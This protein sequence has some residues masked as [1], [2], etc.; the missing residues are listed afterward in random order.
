MKEEGACF[1]LRPGILAAR[2]LAQ[3]EGSARV[4][5][6]ISAIADAIGR[7]EQIMAEIDKRWPTRAASNDGQPVHS[8]FAQL[9]KFCLPMPS[10]TLGRS[11]RN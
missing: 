8:S 11:D 2:K 6:T 7:V 3:Y 9:N 5:A 1:S 10:P 4:P